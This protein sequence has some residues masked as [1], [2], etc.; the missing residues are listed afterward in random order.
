MK[1]SKAIKTYIVISESASVT[2]AYA[3]EKLSYYLGKI[4]GIEAETV[5]SADG[6][7]GN[8]IFPWRS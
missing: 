8:F 6:K 7:E 2:E 3:A 5:T 4:F 1:F